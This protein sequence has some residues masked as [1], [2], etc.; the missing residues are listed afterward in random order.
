MS[1]TAEHLASWAAKPE[2]RTLLP[3]LVRRL[4]LASGAKLRRL[5][6]P[7][8]SA[9]DLPGVDGIVEASPGNAWIPEGRSVW[10]LSCERD[11]RRKASADL[12]KRTEEMPAEERAST[13][14]LF[15]TPRRWGK[16]SQWVRGSGARGWKEVRAYDADDLVPWLEAT[17]AVADWF[18]EQLGLAGPGVER[19]ERF[20][21]RWAGACKP[22][23]TPGALAAGRFRPL[24]SLRRALKE[25]LEPDASAP[26]SA[27]RPEGPILLRADSEEEAVAVAA[28][29]LARGK[30]LA[31]RTLVVTSAE[32]W[33]FVERNPTQRIALCA[34]SDLHEKRTTR[35]GLCLIVPAA[36]RTE[37]VAQ[38]EERERQEKPEG[39][40][41]ALPRPAEKAF[42]KALERLG[43]EPA[44]AS[45]LASRCGRSWSV[46]RRLHAR[47]PVAPRWR[48]R[49]ESRTLATLALLPRF[50]PGRP[51]TMGT[52]E[53]AVAQVDGRPWEEIER[54]LRVLADQPDPPVVEA[55]ST[56]RA[57]SVFELTLVM[58]PRITGE[59]VDRF[60]EMA[61]TLFERIRDEGRA[62]SFDFPGTVADSLARLAVLGPDTLP[63]HPK[64]DRAIERLLDELLA[65]A[66]ARGWSN[67]RTYLWRFAEAAPE[68][69]LERIGAHLESSVPLYRADS[70][71][72]TSFLFALEIL[73][74][75]PD[76]LLRVCEILCELSGPD[77]VFS[78]RQSPEETLYRLFCPWYPQCGAEHPERL[79]L[80]ETLADRYPS[81]A[82]RLFVR[83]L[84]PPGVVTRN[85]A[86]R[87]RDPWL[88][89]VAPTTR[90][91]REALCN[92]ARGAL[93]L[94]DGD[95]RRLVE[96]LGVFSTLRR[97]G[98]ET[99]LLDAV[100]RFLRG[101]PTAEQRET[102]RAAFRAILEKY[103]DETNDRPDLR[104]P[105]EIYQRA[106]PA[107]LVLRHRWLFEPG[108]LS[109]P[110]PEPLPREKPYEDRVA[111]LRRDAVVEIA[112]ADGVD[113]LLAL[114]RTAS[115]P[116]SVTFACADALFG[117]RA[118]FDAF[119]DRASGSN[120]EASTAR[121]FLAE[122]LQRAFYQGCF[123]E[124]L[125]LILRHARRQRWAARDLAA[126]TISVPFDPALPA[127]LDEA[128]PG[129]AD[130]Y[131]RL[132]LREFLEPAALRSLPLV[133]DRLL[134]AGRA[135]DAV[136]VL[137]LR[138]E[139]PRELA[140]VAATQIAR[141]AACA[142]KPGPG[143]S[144]KLIEPLE[145]SFLDRALVARLELRI[146]RPTAQRCNKLVEA[147]QSLW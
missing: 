146:L 112:H 133:L 101:E 93:T 66:H 71:E 10:E 54:D 40:P 65:G 142:D 27:P 5:E 46:F 108:L 119:L 22:A 21:E 19:P 75:D 45:R 30:S 79:A 3:D 127:R 57:Q 55:G 60:L 4:V 125:H 50:T 89:T 23:I 121:A 138:K 147:C 2:A 106:A 87:W 91:V 13:T 95:P 8:G 145:A 18:G 67:L 116:H 39:I 43:F 96:L 110:W 84:Q 143:S 117:D 33:R 104:R 56:W 123:V 122:W 83:M 15:V 100:E 68:V 36:R 49:P 29:L 25:R 53:A 120:P 118:L 97:L 64:I 136:F 9:V 47:A 113:G 85:A 63:S 34:S 20:F 107:D 124:I 109:L 126:A 31:A 92:A 86:P 115:R 130:A 80:L 59:Q 102:I 134:S 139:P 48:D 61:R 74:W 28:A 14:F 98:R 32:G 7:G 88:R 41:I 77:L 128:C 1:I 70:S 99:A 135:D 24:R 69:V 72:L 103:P 58:G 105:A 11:P 141:I 6:L 42:A 129:A 26:D 35:P 131:W 140:A 144:L 52:E 111:Q 73:A 78:R 38:G 114:A 137:A 44:R 81:Q 94:A 132:V 16:K 62:P 12:E 76:R 37:P 17:P 51:S 82:F 90:E